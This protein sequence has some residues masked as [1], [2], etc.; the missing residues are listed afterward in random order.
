MKVVSKL[1]LLCMIPIL[2]SSCLHNGES[3]QLTY[4]SDLKPPVEITIEEAEAMIPFDIKEPSVPFQ[5][6]E[7][8]IRILATNDPYDAVE[9]TY[10]NTEQGLN[11]IMMITNSKVKT[12]PHGK[13]GQK[14]AN[15]SQTWDQG[16]DHI[17]AIYWRNE[18]LTY[19]LVA[20]KNNNL[21]PL[22]DYK[23]LIEI[24]DTI[25]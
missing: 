17:S 14:L 1:L 22:Y 9:I 20:G 24:A 21:E 7:K 12:S 13:K 10:A 15:G 6:T 16:N 5:T 3:P 25:Q 8:S 23:T 4:D 2:L 19:S 11:L 18:G